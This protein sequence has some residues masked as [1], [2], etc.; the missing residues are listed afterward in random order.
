MIR[1]SLDLVRRNIDHLFVLLISL[2]L[3]TIANQIVAPLIWV[4]QPSVSKVNEIGIERTNPFSGYYSLTLDYTI[5]PEKRWIWDRSMAWAY[6]VFCVRE[7]VNPRLFDLSDVAE[8]QFAL[9]SNVTDS[10]ME[11][12][13]FINNE[14][15]QYTKSITI[16]TQWLI[17]SVK[18]EDLKPMFKNLPPLDLRYVYSFGFAVKARGGIRSERMNID[19]VV[20]VYRNGKTTTFEDFER[21]TDDLQEF[22]NIKGALGKW[23]YGADSSKN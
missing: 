10:E 16:S 23:V 17:Y 13:I 14:F 7:P 6:L 5:C 12:N 11:F 9:K 19:K 3:S 4:S 15:T 18:P 21:T 20:F 22:Q 2:L 8:I 1:K